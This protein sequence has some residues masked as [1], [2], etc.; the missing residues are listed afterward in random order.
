MALA[1]FTDY[2]SG[3][4]E[5]MSNDAA[6]LGKKGEELAVKFLKKRDSKYCS[7]TIGAGV[8]KSTSLP[9]MESTLLSLK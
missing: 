8:E 1:Q 5:K 7:E 9:G 6:A 2:H 3:V 4:C